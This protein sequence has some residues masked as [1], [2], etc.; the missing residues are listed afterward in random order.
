MNIAYLANIRLPTEKAHG[1]QIM[2]TCEALTHA[3]ADVRLIVPRRFTPIQEDP[4]SY[5]G[6][7]KCF[8]IMR[9]TTLDTVALG[10][11]GFWVQQLTFG[12]CALFV[13]LREKSDAIYS[14]DEFLLLLARVVRRPLFWEAHMPRFNPLTRFVLPALSGVITI[15]RGLRDFYANKQ[16]NLPPLL[17]AHDGVSLRQFDVE[18]S[19]AR[20]REQFGLPPEQKIVLYAG[21]FAGWKGYTTLLES[22]Q[23]FPPDTMLVM[24]GGS[25][26][27][28]VHLKKHYPRVLFLGTTP[29]AT[30]PV[31]QKAADVL[32][33]PNSATSEV[34]RLYTSPLKVFAAMSSGVPLVA[35]DIPSL[36]EV[37]DD[38]MA[39]FFTPDNPQSLAETVSATLSDVVSARKKGAQA[40][41]EAQ[42][43]AWEKRGVDIIRFIKVF[44]DAY[45]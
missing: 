12:M 16:V 44:Y 26:E 30:L 1:A 20:A 7:E 43:Y 41:V 24:A 3:G 22:E 40:A 25:A 13:L 6:V 17:V 21:A 11:V 8:R 32:V 39:S 38:E 18:I 19:K 29:Y 9:V 5:Y 45:I 23:Y 35:S 10:R 27:Q 4:F 42:A 34:S 2:H 33:V 14:R 37:L 15:S 31:L 36:R 28:V